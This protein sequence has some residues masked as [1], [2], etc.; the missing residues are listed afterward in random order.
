M[1]IAVNDISF[2]KGCTT[3]YAAREA[4]KQFASV[5]MGLKDERV[6]NVT[7][8]NNIVNSPNVNKTT[9]IAPE[10]TLIQALND[11]KDENME[12]F[13]FI[14]QML[15]MCGEE[16]D[17]CKDEF[18]VAGYKSTYCAYHRKD[19][20]LSLVSDEVFS[21]ELVKGVLNNS[22]KCEIKNISNDEHK[23][24]Y[25]EEL[26]FRE[27]ELNKKH[28]SKVYYRPGGIKVD[29][30]P[31]TDELGQKLLNKAIEI[32]GK[33]FAVDKEHGN[34]IFEFHHSYANKYHGFRRE[35]ISKDLQRK[36]YREF[37]I[38]LENN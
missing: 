31:E 16:M 18:S 2:L 38:G 11:I 5:G 35:D 33:L 19:F 3:P 26:G 20:L 34:R 6:S 13:L 15:A 14:L 25:W 36:I 24:T 17:E 21:N 12:M 7:M 23:Y 32:N 37:G 9:V 28:G 1:I 22:V 30:A 8:E 29:I 27:Y 10:Y 4:L